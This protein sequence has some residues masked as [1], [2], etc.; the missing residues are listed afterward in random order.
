[1][2][3]RRN[4]A[5]SICF[6]K[7]IFV[8][9]GNESDTGSIDSI[10]KYSLDFDRWTICRVR[11]KEPIHD[12]ISFNLGGN[13]VLIFG[14]ASNAQANHT[15]EVY[16]LTCEV[17]GPNETTFTVGKIYVPPVYDS[18]SGQLHFYLGYG[19]CELDHSKLNIGSLICTC[20]NG[21]TKTVL[22]DLKGI[23]ESMGR[24]NSG[25]SMILSRAKQ[26]LL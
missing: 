25:K 9:G 21:A 17:L 22:P 2:T 11:L 26:E 5:S 6:G 1:M 19:D 8:F 18:S 3:L 12:S 4:G 7:N 13:R 15:F 14:G 16:D 10:E 24:I 20:R 23:E